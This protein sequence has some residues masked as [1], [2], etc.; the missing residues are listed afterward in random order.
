MNDAERPMNMLLP[1]SRLQERDQSDPYGRLARLCLALTLA[2]VF[3]LPPANALASPLRP[4]GRATMPAGQPSMQVSAGFD[5]HYRNGSWVP[6]HITLS[7]IGA[8]FSG[9]LS[10]TNPSGPIVQ[11]PFSTVPVST[12]E[13][14]ITLPHG[15]Q[16]QVTMY[17]PIY[18]LQGVPGITVHLLDL[19]GNILQSQ[20]APLH[21]LDPEDIFVGLLSDQSTGFDPLQALHLPSQ[22]GLMV[23]QFLN[24]QTMPAMAAVLN[25]FKLIV[26]DNFT[27]RRL[28]SE[29]LMALQTWVNRGGAL[30]EIGGPRW[31]QTLGP[32]PASLLPVSV[33]GTSILPEGIHL[34]PIGGPTAEGIGD[35]ASA[36]TIQVPIT[37][38]TAT[39]QSNVQTIISAG[40]TPL[41]VQAYV[42]QG[43]IFYLA[44]DPTAEPIV[45]WPDVSTLWKDLLFRSRG[46]QLIAPIFDPDPSVGTAYSLA[47]MQH[48]LFP[49]ATP[50]PWVL[51]LFFLGYLI[52][53]GP[54]RWVIIRRLKRREWSWRIVLSAIVVFSLLNYG[55]A[56]YQQGASIVSNSLSII[57]LSRAGPF[58]HSTAYVGLYVPFVSANGTVQVRLPENTLVQPF[59]DYTLQ[60]EQ[61]TITASADGMQVDIS[62]AEIRTLDALQVE[63]DLPVQGGF[64]SHLTLAGGMLTGTVTNTLPTA[65]S[66]VYVLMPHRIVG[67]G[68]LDPGQTSMVRLA[69]PFASTNVGPSVCK[70]LVH[71]VSASGSGTPVQYSNLL[72]RN[73]QQPLGERQRHVSFLAFLLTSLQCSS[74][75]WVPASASATLIGWAD[76][77]LDAV[78]HI[79]FNGISAGGLHETLL[80]APLDI[81]YAA[82]SLT[83][84]QDMLPGQLVDAEALNIRHLSAV[85]YALAK[86]QATFEYNLPMRVHAQGMTLT[87]PVD[88]STQPYI[89]AGKSPDGTS[90]ISL[91]NW[92]K[93][94]WDTI[95]LTP[96]TSFTTQNTR[97]YVSS[98]GRVLVQYVNQASGLAEIAFTKPALSITGIISRN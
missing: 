11:P 23:I 26:L 75:P 31:R 67:I 24:A 29:Q 6:I 52:V 61:A 2:I 97:A 1:H 84:P 86:G 60:K 59:T 36:G 74:T 71:Q 58:A 21:M 87:E 80:L 81:T 95:M 47:K 4:S 41:L 7:N 37:V 8:D 83:L 73:V 46:E 9:A 93:G 34:L 54:A 40:I 82:G 13:E 85:T 66:D 77:P 28:T 94:S 27:T 78:N 18:T 17:L 51:L 30:I 49:L 98:A 39:V 55:I 44:F 62:G 90:H 35:P 25:N 53:L 69:M 10:I 79:T 16:K 14:P 56:L 45:S 91:Y 22:N 48:L 43:S 50:S 76:Q 63:Q 33:H 65:L 19:H 64:I 38:S 42:G 96:S 12:Y 92:Q 15:I 57:R 89:L 32:L 20:S 68:N 88:S 72:T 70:S 5:T 3:L